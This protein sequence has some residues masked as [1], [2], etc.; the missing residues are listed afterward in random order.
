MLFVALS[1]LKGLGK[2]KICVGHIPFC[3]WAFESK[4]IFKK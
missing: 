4:G 1:V 2:V 3:V